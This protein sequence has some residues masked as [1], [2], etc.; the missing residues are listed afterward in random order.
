[1]VDT[2]VF[3]FSADI[4]C[5]LYELSFIYP[6]ILPSVP[7]RYELYDCSIPISPLP[8]LL[9]NPIRSAASDLKDMSFYILLQTIRLLYCQIQTLLS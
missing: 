5:D 1:M 2:I 9:A 8:P 7:E 4:T 6:Y 3:P